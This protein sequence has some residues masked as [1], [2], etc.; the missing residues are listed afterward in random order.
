[1]DELTMSASERHAVA[2]AQQDWCDGQAPDENPFPAHSPEAHAWDAEMD[3]L[4][5]EE[6]KRELAA[7]M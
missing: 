4:L 2:R 3:T 1:M 7:P 5:I 6:T